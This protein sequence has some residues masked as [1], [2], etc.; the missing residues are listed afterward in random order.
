MGVLGGD[1]LTDPAAYA[2]RKQKMTRNGSTFTLFLV[3]SLLIAV[4]MCIEEQP[5]LI[6]GM[7]IPRPEPVDHHCGMCV[8]LSLCVL[9]LL[10]RLLAGGEGHAPHD[11]VDGEAHKHCIFTTFGASTKHIRA[12]SPIPA[13]MLYIHPCLSMYFHVLHMHLT[14]PCTS[15]APPI[16]P[17]TF[18]AFHAF[19]ASMHP[20]TFHA[21]KIS[22]AFV[23]FTAFLL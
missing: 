11:H 5:Q 22:R 9:S 3:F 12:L 14:F 20:C 17:C 1:H 18:H 23:P 8:R 15:H 21:P 2:K 4:A 6:P 13:R 16:T 7:E 19:H 10:T